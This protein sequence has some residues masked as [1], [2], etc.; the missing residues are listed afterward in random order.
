MP[1]RPSLALAA[2]LVCGCPTSPGSDGGTDA[3]GDVG[4][5]VTVDGPADAALLRLRRAQEEARAEFCRCL[6]RRD[7]SFTEARCLAVTA[8]SPD[9]TACE[10]EAN[11]AVRGGLDPY[12]RCVTT[13]A[14]AQGRCFAAPGACTD[15]AVLACTEDFG[16]AVA[17]CQRMIAAG[18]GA[19]YVEAYRACIEARVTGPA[20]GCPDDP[21]ASSSDVGMAV[22]SGT[23]LLAGND[24][25][26]LGGCFA[27]PDDAMRARGAPDRA[28][29]WIAPADGRYQLDTIG[30]G[31]DTIL[32]VRRACADGADVACADDIEL[33]VDQDSCVTVD[34]TTGE[35]LVVIVDGF[36][37]LARGDFVVNIAAVAPDAVCPTMA[38]TPPM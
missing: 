4:S 6:P 11:A 3:P 30:S 18:V 5:D 7:A 19:A 37:D 17:A 1:K 26:P 31:L 28:F 23:T 25:E 20:M 33:R 9:V 8:P 34:A 21:M 2:V 10:D 16:T 35:E 24:T 36:G 15:A 22:F 29:R 38:V 12:Y 27:D 32:Y 13:A 14:D